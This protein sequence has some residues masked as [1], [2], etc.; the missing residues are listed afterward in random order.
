MCSLVSH[1][2]WYWV[3]RKPHFGAEF[4]LKRRIWSLKEVD[5][6]N[7]NVKNENNHQKLKRII[8]VLSRPIM[9]KKILIFFYSPPSTTVC[10]CFGRLVD[11]LSI[12]Y[13]YQLVKAVQFKSSQWPS[14]LKEFEFWAVKIEKGV[15]TY[16]H[17]KRLK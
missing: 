14:K 17:L 5:L 9:K 15:R 11:V 1:I 12:E 16:L 13:M 8:I 7:K 3:V 2:L 10:F 6:C 4:F